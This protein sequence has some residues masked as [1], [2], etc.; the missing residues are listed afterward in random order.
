MGFIMTHP[1]LKMLIGSVLWSIAF[2]LYLLFES[3]RLFF[4][5][6]LGLLSFG[7][8]TYLFIEESEKFQILRKLIIPFMAGIFIFWIFLTTRL[9]IYI[10]ETPLAEILTDLTVIVTVSSLN[11]LGIPAVHQGNLIIFPAASKVPSA[12]IDAR[13]GGVHS[14]L[15]FV[16]CF[17]VVLLREGYTVSRKKIAI[18][19]LIGIAGTLFTNYFR[20]VIVCLVGIFYGA[21]LMYFV[22][23]YAGFALF[24]TWLCVFWY[25]A[26]SYLLQDVELTGII[27]EN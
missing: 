1:K 14:F 15:I 26:L 2:I 23:N 11:G 4:L 10:L 7:A 22:H 6:P 3:T 16:C 20:V 27:S 21:E 18:S 19:S 5:P 9:D 24:L 12:Y 25:L 17:I 13:C 8:G